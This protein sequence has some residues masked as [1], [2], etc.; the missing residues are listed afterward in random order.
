MK[1]S[2]SLDIKV[3]DGLSADELVDYV[4]PG[5]RV[6]LESISRPETTSGGVDYTSG[7]LEWKKD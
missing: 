7:T 6:A 1:I 5:V 3:P 2:L 4:L